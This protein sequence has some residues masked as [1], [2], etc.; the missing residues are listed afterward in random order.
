MNDFL[1]AHEVI[2]SNFVWKIYV[3]RQGVE[4]LFYEKKRVDLEGFGLP[5]PDAIRA[6]AQ[7]LIL[8]VPLLRLLLCA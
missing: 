4:T 1:E 6:L 8:E 3:E 5:R 7:Y 2:I